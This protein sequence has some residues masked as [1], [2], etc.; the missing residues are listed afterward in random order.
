VRRAVELKDVEEIVQDRADNCCLLSSVQTLL[1][2]CPSAMS[3]SAARN[4]M[5]LRD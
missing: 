4:K 2:P 3:L 5:L 1:F